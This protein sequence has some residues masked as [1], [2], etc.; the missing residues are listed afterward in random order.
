[1][2]VHLRHQRHPDEV[3]RDAP[4]FG[5]W[6]VWLTVVSLMSGWLV[7]GGFRVADVISAGR[8]L[9]WCIAVFCAVGFGAFMWGTRRARQEFAA[10]VAQA[11]QI[12]YTCRPGHL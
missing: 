11:E 7:I 6:A 9:G 4:A 2:A 3:D 1:V 8:A 10:R 5:P 12:R